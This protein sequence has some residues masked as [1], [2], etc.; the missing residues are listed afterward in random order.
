M[1]IRNIAFLINPSRPEA[2]KA[3]GELTPLLSS[4]GFNLYTV[5]DVAIDGIKKVTA[6][7]LPELEIAVVLG[8]DGTILRAAEVTISRDIPL[9]GINLG[10]V[11]FLAEV[12]RPSIQAIAD[13]IINKSYVSESRMVLK[14]SVERDGKEISSGWAL[15]EV[16]VERDGTTMVELFVE[17]DRRPLSHWGCDGVICSTPTGSTAY[18]FSAGGPVLWPE[19]EALVLLPISAHAL[20]S[21]PMVVSPKSEI[22]V[23]VESSEALLSADALRK[24]PLKSGDRVVITRDAQ[25]IK[26]SHVS[27][28]LFTDRLVAKFKLPVE[29]WRGE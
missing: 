19:I 9:L 8:G 17:I 13:S 29:G 26:L 22:I 18:A 15:N 24:I 14:F 4:A 28:T 21:R 27:S 7:E 20:F 11:G 25:T 1:S 23:T 3:A 6:A 10:Q 16:T 2:L 12:D 5:S